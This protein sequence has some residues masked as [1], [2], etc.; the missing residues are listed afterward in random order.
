MDVQA[1]HEGVGEGGGYGVELA[2]EVEGDDDLGVVHLQDVDEVARLPGV[3]R[4]LEVQGDGVRRE[5]V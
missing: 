1:V 3:P 5:M 2:H 4:Q